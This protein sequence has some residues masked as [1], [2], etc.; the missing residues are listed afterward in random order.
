M[1]IRK[2][3]SLDVRGEPLGDC[4]FERRRV[5]LPVT[6]LHPVH[7]DHRYQFSVELFP[8][9]VVVKR[10]LVEGHV[11]LTSDHL[12]D[13]SVCIVTQVA[14]RF[15]NEG[16]G[17]GHALHLMLSAMVSDKSNGESSASSGDLVFVDIDNTLLPGAV[18]F[19]FA[20]EAWRQ[21]FLT[22]RDVF[23][24]LFEQR[25]FRRR[26]ETEER[27]ARVQERALS[28][29]RDHSVEQFE[30]VARATFHRRVKPRL[31]RDVVSLLHTHQA[32]GSEVH[33]VSASP[34][35]LVDVIAENLG[36]EGG[37]GTALRV[38][39]G[40]FTGE[41]EG[42]LLRG[43]HKAQAA[44]SLASRRDVDLDRCA[45]MSD[46]AADIPLLELVGQ[47]L[48]VNPDPHLLRE[49]TRRDWPV[50][51]PEGTHRYRRL[52]SR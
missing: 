30:A 38:D 12:I 36:F 11:G 32:A 4:L 51:W 41:L 43:E 5:D 14:P 13:D 33:L 49:A 20:V 3:D 17:D 29:V 39:T 34:Q 45:A 24:A 8:E 50:L 27:V 10:D 47:P 35:G 15:T 18:V 19:L 37:V 9:R 22:S 48:A 1:A 16:H 28:L 2:K 31:F 21:G 6:E 44:V 40:V 23:P 52:R 7:E 46:S 25:H 42:A 26:G